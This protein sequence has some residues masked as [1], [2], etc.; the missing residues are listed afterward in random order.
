MVLNQDEQIQAYA[1]NLKLLK[2]ANILL[3]LFILI[4]LYVN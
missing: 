3:F 2:F 1:G 4:Y